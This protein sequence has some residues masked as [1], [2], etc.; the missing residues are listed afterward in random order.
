M[1]SCPDPVGSHASRSYNGLIQHSFA[2][3]IAETHYPFN[4]WTNLDRIAERF[5]AGGFHAAPLGGCID[6]KRS[7][8]AS[9]SPLA[10]HG[11]TT[12]KGLEA[13]YLKPDAKPLPRVFRWAE[14]EDRMCRGPY[15]EPRLIFADT[16]DEGKASI[17]DFLLTR[18]KSDGVPE[19]VTRVLLETMAYMRSRLFGFRL[20]NRFVNVMLP[21]ALLRSNGSAGNSPRWLVQPLVSFIRGGRDRGR[22]RSTYSL[23][24]FLIPV[25]KDG[26]SL[27][28]RPMS[29]SEIAL[30]VS[31]GWGFAAAAPTPPTSQFNVRGPLPDYILD[32][33][34]P[35]QPDERN[36]RTLRHT[37]ESIAFA[38]G[39][40]V[41]QGRSGRVDPTTERRIG[42]DVVMALGSARA[43]SV[44]VVDPT[45]IPSKVNVPIKARPFPGALA[46]LMSELAGDDRMPQV[47][48]GDCRK[49]R[50][51][52]PLSDGDDYV[53]GVLPAERCLAL[54]SWGG[55]QC[56]VRASA[57]MQAGS[58][59]YMTLGAAT[60]IGTMRAID[61]RLEK[62]DGAGPTKIAAID[63]EIA[64]DLAEI[65]DLDITHESYRGIYRRLR[66][67]FG[68]TRDYKTLQDKM[69]TLYRATST[70]HARKSERLLAGLTAAIVV[71]SV[72][73]LVGTV[74]LIGNGG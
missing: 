53:I 13:T 26:T 15:I 39:L 45:L 73:I 30:M 19:D 42:N 34:G 8:K 18:G 3:Q 7:T 35:S 21:H 37:V 41:T 72:F 47:G 57:L 43:S 60:A 52:R 54:V 74:V 32:L 69:E 61:R 63:R 9:H 64:A 10:A 2:L 28:D 14:T 22:L 38:I 71:L 12:L 55:I 29:L 56:G 58:I 51:D 40:A 66:N 24:V 31:P 62:L 6:L 59:A 46:H 11:L 49:F 65:Y 50:L 33:A 48:D 25:E 67:R 1:P 17:N 44:V 27:R 68:I 70:F 5:D 23:T 20:A 36:N 4:G 16:Y